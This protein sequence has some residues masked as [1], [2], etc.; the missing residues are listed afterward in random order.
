MAKVCVAFATV[1][2]YFALWENKELGEPK[3]VP[4]NTAPPGRNMLVSRSLTSRAICAY[5]TVAALT[6]QAIIRA[7]VT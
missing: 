3:P 5:P 6:Q 2:G 1:T 4:A 7:S